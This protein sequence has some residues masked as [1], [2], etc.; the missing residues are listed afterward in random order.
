[1]PSSLHFTGPPDFLSATVTALLKK[2]YLYHGAASSRAGNVKLAAMTSEKGLK[3]HES[4]TTYVIVGTKKYREEMEEE[5]NKNPVLF[6][7]MACQSSVSEIYLGEVIH[8]QGLEAGVMA[9]ID[10]RLGKVRGAMYKVKALIEDFRLQA[11]TG[12]EGAWI[13][14][15]K[16]ILPTLISGCGSWI[17]IGKKVYEKVDEIQC[18]YLRMIYSCPP[19][20]PKPSLRSQAGMLDAKHYIWVEKICV[21]TDIMHNK[22]EQDENYAREVLKEQLEE[23]W[24]GLTKEVEEICQA[25]GLPN[26][27]KEYIHRKRVVDAIE[28]HHM[29]EVKEQMEPLSKMETLRLKDTRR[30]QPYMKMKSL[31]NSR[32]EFLWQT[33]IIE[34]RMN[35]KGKYP[36]NEY[37][38]P[39][40]PEGRE[41]GGTLETSNHLLECRVYKDLREG[42]DVEGVTEDRVQYLRRVIQRRTA[43][44]KLL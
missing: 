32:M 7:K 24:E 40:C 21:L 3:A 27:C 43:L 10:N 23:G 6:G 33:N 35:M 28:I 8:S 9:T 36:K 39:H 15:K 22:E 42:L 11:I 29:K 13:L 4:K 18:E 38:C 1:M 30:M 20:T 31:E 34:T 2:K 5:S 16:S 12:M 14:W 37:Q 44:E 19:S 25:A 41:A 17:G 26:A